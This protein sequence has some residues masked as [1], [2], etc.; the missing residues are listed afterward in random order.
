MPPAIEYPVATAITAA[1]K[2]GMAAATTM[3]S[4]TPVRGNTMSTN[5]HLKRSQPSSENNPASIKS[6]KASATPGSNTTHQTKKRP[7]RR[8]KRPKN[9]CDKSTVTTVTTPTRQDG[10]D[11][12][13]GGGTM[14]PDGTNVYD[15]VLG[16]CEDLL[17]AS[18]EAQRL[19]RL[20]MAS[21]YQLL[22]HTRLVG[23]GK[24]FDRS[25]MMVDQQKTRQQLQQRAQQQ[26]EQQPRK[27]LDMEASSS[28][29]MDQTNIGALEAS[30]SNESNSI[31][32]T[33][34]ES[35][36]NPLTKIEAA[37]AAAAEGASADIEAAVAAAAAEGTSPNPDGS[38]PVPEALQQLRSILPGNLEM[39]AS[40]MEHLAR[41]AVELHHQ[42]TGRRKSADGLLASP[43]TGGLLAVAVAA[44][45]NNNASTAEEQQAPSI[46]TTAKPTTKK[47]SVAWTPTE[48][49]IVIKAL[50][51]GKDNYIIASTL[52]PNK[53]VAQVHAF[54]KNQ[55]QL[56]KVNKLAQQQEHQHQQQAGEVTTTGPVASSSS[57]LSVPQDA[58]KPQALASSG[59]SG[60]G[61]SSA[62]N[63]ATN[64]VQANIAV[65]PK[66]GG[67]GRKPPTTA[68]NT[69][70]NVMMDVRA[71]LRTAN[72]KKQNSTVAAV[73]SDPAPPA[74]K[75]GN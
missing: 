63:N 18:T 3:S 48:T 44:S 20:K 60:N 49:A 62:N 2:D 5:P 50:K 7:Y 26:K 59:R 57:T 47:S 28:I 56:H 52:L 45:E 72:Q 25:A 75:E 8:T 66:R 34:G 53:T 70:P 55:L 37:V 58:S 35:K 13:Y 69:V 65:P 9:Y 68:M 61:S 29:P 27:Q 4:T 1:T 14:N 16:E 42:R 6:G 39:D 54:V 33:G 22:L 71:L 12:E 15:A 43:I 74:S 11:A 64:I 67:R 51:E 41:A 38:S 10:T 21:A 30:V 40:M 46:T 32:T 23:L 31:N 36:N 24:R 17:R 73:T 19:G